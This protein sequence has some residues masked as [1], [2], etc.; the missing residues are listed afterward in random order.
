MT[1]ETDDNAV[2]EFIEYYSKMRYSGNPEMLNHLTALHRLRDERLFYHLTA[3]IPVGAE[4]IYDFYNM[5][6]F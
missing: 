5:Q 2:M 6:T 4:Y 3:V 1:N